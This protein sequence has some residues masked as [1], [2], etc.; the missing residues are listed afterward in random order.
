AMGP[1]FEIGIFPK[2]MKM[3]L[4]HPDVVAYYNS[5]RA[6]GF[7]DWALNV[8]KDIAEV[9]CDP[10]IV[11]HLGRQIRDIYNVRDGQLRFGNF[12]LGNS[13]FPTDLN[14]KIWFRPTE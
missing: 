12:P 3:T 9:S 14:Q 8:A 6:C 2:S 7:S 1:G 5:K 10:A 4:I 13:A 11:P